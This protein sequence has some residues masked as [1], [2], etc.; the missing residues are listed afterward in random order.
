MKKYA[1]LLLVALCSGYAFAIAA[2]E[3]VVLIK[4][5]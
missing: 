5:R 2:R 4:S 1:V 3:V